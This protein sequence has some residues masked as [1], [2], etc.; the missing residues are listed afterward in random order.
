[1]ID[2]YC[3]KYVEVERNNLNI[4]ASIRPDLVIP[5][6]LRKLDLSLETLTEP[7]KF[8]AAVKCLVSGYL[9]IHL[10]IDSETS[11]CNFLSP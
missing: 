7:F 2:P 1:M 5:P 4:L 8:T 3:R 6:L 11:A 10:F 9:F